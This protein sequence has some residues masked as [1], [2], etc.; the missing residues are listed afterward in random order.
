MEEVKLKVLGTVA[1]YPKDNKNCP[2]YL[3]KYKNHNILFDCGNGSTRLLNLPEDLNN[4]SI[5]IT[6]LHPDHA[7]DLTSLLQ[8]IF[9]Y[10][11]HNLIH[12]DIN[13][14][15]PETIEEIY[16][17]LEDEMTWMTIK[18]GEKHAIDYEYIK[19][20]ADIAGVKVH[21]IEEIINFKDFSI[22]S[23]NVPHQIEAYAYRFNSN[24]GD[25]TYSG[26]TGVKNN[27]SNFAKNSNIFICESTFLK[28]NPHT[29]GGHLYTYEAANIAKSANVDKLLLTHFWP[30]IDKEK[31]VE[32]AKEIFPNTE[33]AEEGKQYI[34]RR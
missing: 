8:T 16:E 33:V 24:D 5:F 12:S 19:K 13:L 6:H 9:V 10:R 31:Y 20:Y 21:N 27:L 14:Y 15:L 17:Y 32:E 29:V 4:L 1:P 30:E 3:I 22:T 34:L 2:G 28:E 26:D 7:G 25:I 18:I 23:E 11:C